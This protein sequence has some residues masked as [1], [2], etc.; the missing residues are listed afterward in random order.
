MRTFPDFAVKKAR[1]EVIPMIDVM[2]FLLVFFVLISI[3]VIPA[4][5][6][7]VALPS[8]STLEKNIVPKK[9][10][11]TITKDSRLMLDDAPIILGDLEPALLNK[12]NQLGSNF[13]VVINGDEAASLQDLVAVM[14]VLKNLQIP[15]MTISSK[16]RS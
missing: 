2:M 13:T 6:L 10:I 3:N 1:I 7:K 14:E 8:L 4:G 15:S 9:I 16:K 5:G 11:I 12:K